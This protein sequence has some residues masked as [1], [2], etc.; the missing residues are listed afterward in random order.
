MVQKW[1][2]PSLIFLCGCNSSSKTENNSKNLKS[3]EVVKKA[4]TRVTNRVQNLKG[5]IFILEYHKV[6]PT[7]GLYARSSEKFRNDLTRL[8]KLGFRPVTM[9]ELV[10]DKMNLPPGA[11]PVVLTFDDSSLSQFKMLPDGTID[12]ECAVGIM[13]SFS[14]THPDFPVKA[15]FYVLPDSMFCQKGLVDAKLK[16]LKEWGCELGSHTISHRSLRKL[17]DDEI[18]KELGE[19]IEYIRSVGFEPLTMAVPYG[20]MPKNNKILSKFSYK[21]KEYGFL[22]NVRSMARPCRSM[23]VDKKEDPLRMPRILGSDEKFAL[24]YW[25]DEVDKGNV[26]LYVQ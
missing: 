1:F 20:N 6:T 14:K 8:H 16:K 24:S 19:S 7:E 10:Q 22:A 9:A 23:H 2:L 3:K 15:T 13:E 26:G 12:P 18:S 17:S 25:L 21:G 11:T 5:D 4:L